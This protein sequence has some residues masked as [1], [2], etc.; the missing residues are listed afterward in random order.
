[1]IESDKVLSN[2]SYPRVTNEKRIV[3]QFLDLL[4]VISLKLLLTL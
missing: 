3:A 1:M 4:Q 2:T